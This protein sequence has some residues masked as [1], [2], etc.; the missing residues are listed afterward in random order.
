MMAYVF[1]IVCEHFE[2]IRSVVK[3]VSV[4]VMN[5][6]VRVQI[7]AK[8]LFHD[9]DV[10]IYISV[11]PRPLMTGHIND[12]V[13]FMILVVVFWGEPSTFVTI[14]HIAPPSLQIGRNQKALCLHRLE[15]A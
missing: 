2:V 6:F 3:F 7:P 14:L 4:Y 1:R 12:F 5:N 8:F 11:S 10:F 13:S 9:K 15:E